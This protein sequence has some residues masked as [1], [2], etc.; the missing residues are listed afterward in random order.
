[1]PSPELIAHLPVRAAG[2]EPLDA[3]ASAPSLTALATCAA[4]LWC[5]CRVLPRYR[6]ST[7][8]A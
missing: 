4:L 7:D 5:A 2:M 6:N 1:M 8:A 3:L